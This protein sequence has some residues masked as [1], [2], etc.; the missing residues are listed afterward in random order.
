MSTYK[1]EFRS[2]GL[3]KNHATFA[4][5]DAFLKLFHINNLSVPSALLGE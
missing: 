1:F 5:I 2:S 3:F 4:P